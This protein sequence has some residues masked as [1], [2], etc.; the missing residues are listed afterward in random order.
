MKKIAPD[1]K[2]TKDH[3]RVC[4]KCSQLGH[5][6]KFCDNQHTATTALVNKVLKLAE[7]YRRYHNI[8]KKEQELEEG[9]VRSEGEKSTTSTGES[10]VEIASTKVKKSPTFTSSSVRILSKFCRNNLANLD[11]PNFR[12]ILKNLTIPSLGIDQ[13]Q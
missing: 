6:S 1:G 8:G 5:T 11:L 10:V 13:G 4:T 3:L 2:I 7:M 12:K 9:E